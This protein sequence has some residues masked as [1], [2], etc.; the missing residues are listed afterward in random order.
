MNTSPK[1]QV[2]NAF[3]YLQGGSNPG[4]VV[5]E[6]NPDNL[7]PMIAKRTSSWEFGP[8]GT[9]VIAGGLAGQG[10]S[11]SKWMISKLNNSVYYR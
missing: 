7:V 9:F 2:G 5:V 3:R 8:E 4:K 6:I 1:S 10:R 11:V